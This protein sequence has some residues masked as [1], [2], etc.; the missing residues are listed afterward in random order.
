M[1]KG[2]KVHKK[3]TMNSEQFIRKH[4]TELLQERNPAMRQEVLQKRN[5]EK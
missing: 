3:H 2:Q 4:W 1:R 5:P